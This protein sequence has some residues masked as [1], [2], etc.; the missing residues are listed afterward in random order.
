MSESV[1]TLSAKEQLKRALSNVPGLEEVETLIQSKFTSDAPALTAISS[2]LFTLGGKRVRPLLALMTGRLFGLS[3]AP[4]EL[5]EVA[6][7]IELIH[8]ATLLHDDII[9]KSALR[10]HSASP[11]AKYGTNPTL[12]AGDFLLTRAFSL[13]AHL[14]R[15]IIDATERACVELTEGE[16][17]ETGLHEQEHSVETMLTIALKKTASLF[18]LA[19]E[20]GAHLAGLPAAATELMG[21]FGETLGISFQIL[22]DVLD[23]VA[24]ES[25]LG[26]PSGTDLRER[27]PSAVNLAWVQ[28]G[29]PLSKQLLSS[30]GTPAEEDSFVA[31]ALLELRTPGHVA[32]KEA[33]ALALRYAAKAE[34]A[35]QRA[36]AAGADAGISIDQHTLQ[37]L[38]TL[39][40]YTVTRVG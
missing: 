2:Y 9:D 27:K 34:S 12:L 32:V 21:E 16:I 1:P 19:C 18:R 3:P 17:L 7:G 26:K 24:D 5:I 40:T 22:D 29:A 13:C 14:D 6:A 4:A 33:R 20:S 15:Y 35:L 23:V 39:V 31:G 28:S 36:A 11:F 25:L 37:Q 8:M 30:P 10:R 38:Q